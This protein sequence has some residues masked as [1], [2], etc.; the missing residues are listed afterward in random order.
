MLEVG[1]R[2]DLPAP[3]ADGK[4]RIPA[5]SWLCFHGNVDL[6]GFSLLMQGNV[7][8]CGSSSETAFLSST[9]LPAGRALIE[10][11]YST[12]IQNIT[13]TAPAG[14]MVFRFTKASDPLAL[15]FFACNISGSQIGD[16]DG[17]DN[18][19]LQAC[20]WVGSHSAR[21]LGTTTGTIGASNS[22][23]VAGAGGPAL[24][25]FPSATRLTRRFRLAD[26][27]FVCPPGTTGI[28]VEDQATFPTLPSCL[29]YDVAFSS[30]G[31]YVD[32]VSGLDNVSDFRNSTGVMQSEQEG[33]IFMDNATDLTA[34]VIT[35]PDT[36]VKVAGNTIVGNLQ[37]FDDDGGTQNRLRYVGSTSRRFLFMGAFGC[38]AGNNRQIAVGL[39]VNGIP[40]P[41]T[42][43]FATTN[44]VGRAEAVPINGSLLL[45]EN[46]YV[47]VWVENRDNSQNITVENGSIH[48]FE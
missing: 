13:L 18:L 37:R 30:T 24:W 11:S 8:V 1:S 21:I 45:G 46:D 7:S 36:P 16:F 38:R 26:S 33:S 10:S 48:V 9:G 19:I 15:D 23:F 32:G 43:F 14:A 28:L 20:A 41:N 29:L 22:I 34:T 47:E 4:I 5:G 2:A 17:V 6:G 42:F 3:G 44:G 40:V 25:H 12:P 27:A 35:A 31:T 39:A